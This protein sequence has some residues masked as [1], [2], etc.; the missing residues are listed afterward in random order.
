MTEV[1]SATTITVVG[2]EGWRGGGAHTHTRVLSLLLENCGGGHEA[3]VI[4]SRVLTGHR[5]C[6]LLT[7]I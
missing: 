4:E 3:F 5:K 6:G 7:Y 2:G 1:G